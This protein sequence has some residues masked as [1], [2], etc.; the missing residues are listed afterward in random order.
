M[1]RK[2]GKGGKG[3]KR[4]T[5]HDSESESVEMIT[6][7]TFKPP[8]PRLQVSMGLVSEEWVHITDKQ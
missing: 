2:G 6:D 3:G 5:P 4:S 8:V 7:L 1:S